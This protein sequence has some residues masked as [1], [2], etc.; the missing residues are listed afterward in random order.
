MESE[1]KPE[2]NVLGVIAGGGAMP[3]MVVR[4]A[5]RAGQRV[6]VVGI[7]GWADPCLA[8]LADRFYW[9]GIGKLGRSIR[10]LLR[11]DARRAI[12]AGSVTKSDMYG[13][14]RILRHLPDLETL[15]L[16]FLRV[17]DK[18]TDSILTAVADIMAERGI[19][20]EPCIK[21]CMDSMA[22][23]GVFTR[24][25]PTAGQLRDM[26][27]GWPL[28]KEMGRLDIGQG[29]AVKEQEVIA[30]E[31]IEGT[32]RMIERAGRLC[33]SG[34]WMLIK[35][36]KPNQ[37]MRFDVP[38]IGPDTIENLKQNGARGLVIEA[39]K[40]F[41]VDKDKVM[42]LADRYG[43]TI[44]ACKDKAPALDPSDEPPAG[45]APFPSQ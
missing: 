30:V 23:E 4:N 5:K 28:A 26:A 40:T 20:M 1:S 45:G 6:V 36:A 12:L 13:R 14:F 11:E 19:H 2:S 34:G 15:K 17:P 38:T 29:I 43:I 37:D 25:R 35:V 9:N 21:Y 22:R 42:E 32:D 3:L 10:L 7:R 18:R 16:W 8:E 27:F 39:E 33:R 24:S 44:V 31:A 41:V